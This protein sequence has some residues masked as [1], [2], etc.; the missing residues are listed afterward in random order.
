VRRG[1]AT[2]AR[3]ARVHAGTIA[4]SGAVDRAA[5]GAEEAGDALVAASRT[6]DEGRRAALLAGLRRALLDPDLPLG[7][8]HARVRITA[9]LPAGLQ[10][11]ARELCERFLAGPLGRRL[12]ELR[13]LGAALDVP[14]QISVESA[15]DDPSEPAGSL[16]ARVDIA[17]SDEPGGR[18]RIALWTL[19]RRIEARGETSSEED[20][21]PCAAGRSDELR[22]VARIAAAWREA[23]GLEQDPVCELWRLDAQTIEVLGADD[24]RVS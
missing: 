5:S 7:P 3:M 19:G 1:R 6:A 23:L 21:L 8:E 22:R 12:A 20:G 2:A 24:L 9:A 18:A 10:Q 11:E 15:G 13:A 4:P 17:W 16:A 14:L